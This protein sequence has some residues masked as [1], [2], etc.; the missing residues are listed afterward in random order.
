M[1]FPVLLFS[2][3][4]GNPNPREK[5]SNFNSDTGMIYFRKLK[6]ST[7]NWTIVI[8]IRIFYGKEKCLKAL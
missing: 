1:I 8:H 2:N 4:N 5:V 6:L 3:L 7:T